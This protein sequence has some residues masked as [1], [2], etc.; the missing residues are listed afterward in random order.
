[1]GLAMPR[2]RR[3]N[4]HR[5]QQ[6]ADLRAAGLSL[7]EIGRKLGLTRQRV[8]FI[9]KYACHTRL[10][11]VHCTDCGTVVTQ[12]HGMA[13]NNRTVWCLACLAKR[14]EATFGQRLKAHR[15][16]AGLTLTALER[17][18]GV[19]LSLISDYE[20]GRREPKWQTLAKLIRVLGV[21]WLAVE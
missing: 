19:H 11:P 16:A 3:P 12:L 2:G 9:L 21:E 10:V 4:R 8:Q 5:W 18:S 15:L 13:N 14:P 1:M 17:R 20:C 6:I 7:S